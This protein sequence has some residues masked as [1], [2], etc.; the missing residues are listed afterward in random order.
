MSLQSENG[1][2]KKGFFFF[3]LAVATCFDIFAVTF[4]QLVSMVVSKT[5]AAESVI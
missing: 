4:N 2:E 1:S 3:F 5:E